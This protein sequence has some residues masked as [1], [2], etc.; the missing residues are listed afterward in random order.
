VGIERANQCRLERGL[1]GSERAG[2]ERSVGEHEVCVVVDEGLEG[3][4]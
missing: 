1:G 3:L 2:T 4:G